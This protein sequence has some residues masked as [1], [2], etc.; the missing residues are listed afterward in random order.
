[1]RSR[2]KGPYNSCSMGAFWPIPYARL[3]RQVVDLS[4][5]GKRRLDWFG[6]VQAASV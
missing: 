3:P 1:M 4:K 6:V 2:D 5:E